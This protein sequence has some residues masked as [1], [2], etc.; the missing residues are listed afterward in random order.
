MFLI[1]CNF[2]RLMK[3]EGGKISQEFPI[4]LRI[5]DDFSEFF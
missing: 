3:G 5:L 2:G 1:F 4:F